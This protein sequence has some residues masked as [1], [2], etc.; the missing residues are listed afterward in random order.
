MLVA[1]HVNNSPGTAHMIACMRA[2]GTQS[3][4]SRWRPR[5]KS[6]GLARVQA[7]H[8]EFASL[9][10]AHDLCLNPLTKGSACPRQY[11]ILTL[12]K[13]TRLRT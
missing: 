1:F 10:T 11:H 3:W 12:H 8:P 4:S 2:L 13:P 5:P 6:K 7:L 9:A